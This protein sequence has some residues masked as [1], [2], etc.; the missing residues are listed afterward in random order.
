VLMNKLIFLF[1]SAFILLVMFHPGQITAQEETREATE[2]ANIDKITELNKLYILQIESYRFAEREQV[3][4]KQQYQ[5]LQTLR[6]LEDAVNAT[7]KALIERNNVLLTYLELH[8]FNLQDA[9]GINLT[10]KEDTLS[11]LVE[12]IGV[13]RTYGEKLANISNRDELKERTDEFK[14]IYPQIESVAY[15]SLTLISIGKLQTVHDRGRI[16][17]NDLKALEADQ[18]ADTFRSARYQRA[19]TETERN[20]ENINNQLREANNNYET[21]FKQFNRSGYNNILDK[22][23]PVYTELSQLVAYLKELLT[24]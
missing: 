14:E 15:R 22:L 5:D 20:L 24:I 9:A 8:Y 3:I 1:T 21:R 4:A 17:L 19:I 23:K 10:Y 12:Q 11:V 18:E 2:G 16:I 6:L 13:L 7:K